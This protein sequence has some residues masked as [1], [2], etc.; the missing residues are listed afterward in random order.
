MRLQAPTNVFKF[1]EYVWGYRPAPHHIEMVNFVNEGIDTHQNTVDLE[2]RGAAKTTWA[3]TINITHRI[4][5]DPD[6]RVGLF[7]KSYDHAA[8]MSRAIRWT[9]EGNE[10]FR[11]IYGHLVSDSK[12]TDAQWM[13]AGSRWHGSKDVTMF[14]SGVFGQIVS[15]RFDLIFLDDILDEENTLN[16]DQIERVA[17]WFW[18][19]LYPCLSDHGVIV[20]IGTRW[21][22]GDMAET[23]ITP[24]PDGKG[25][26]HRVE[27]ALMIDE[28]E[29]TG[30][31]SYWPEVWP[32]EKLLEMR[33][34]MGSALF[35]CAYLNDISG[36][37][38][39][40]IFRKQDF[41]Y[42][43]V[44]PEGKY[45]YRM[46]VDLASSTKE[47]ADFTARVVTAED[48]QGNFW[49][50]A[51]RREK[52]ASGHAQFVKDGYDI[53][54]NIEMVVV[55]NQQYQ[56]TLIE[57]I[58]RD[59]PR[60]PIR[61]QKADVDKVTRGRAV[62]ARYEASKVFHHASLRDSDFEV[63]LLSFSAPPKGHDDMLDALGYSMELG[64]DAFSWTFVR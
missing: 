54:P 48:Q 57:E 49:V 13:R 50:L 31:R 17:N 39:G 4:A 27:G 18:K 5:N 2:P 23:L 3:N 14:A 22:A 25:W 46:G 53:Y 20:Y 64:G 15:K 44:L 42:F 34:E 10:R 52:L 7:S 30:Y 47:R 1:G 33:E 11:E 43:N 28:N 19:T 36:L 26:R 55:E 6:I 21:A 63:E 40:N 45:I 24:K 37:M 12:W 59:Y 9:L 41:Q 35:S 38:E 62:A 60:I 29:D 58:M 32:V 8:G 56:S 61:G 51:V 16:R